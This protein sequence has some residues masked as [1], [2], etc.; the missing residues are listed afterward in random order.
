MILGTSKPCLDLPKEIDKMYIDCN[1]ILNIIK[2]YIVVKNT[3]ILDIGCGNGFYVFG[4]AD[5]VKCIYGLDPSNEMLES[6]NNNQKFFNKKNVKFYNGSIENNHL[7]NKFDIVMFTYSLHFTDDS[8]AS[9]LLA[10]KKL[11][12]N[13]LLVIIEPNKKYISSKLLIGH[14]NFDKKYYEL[15]Q[16]QLIKTRHN[17]YMFAKKHTLLYTKFNDKNFIAVIRI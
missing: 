17:V 14:N 10:I 5:Y 13:G 4:L 11:V 6:A 2:S 7:K 8:N 3:S 1:M 12:P 16:Q 9:L 15:K